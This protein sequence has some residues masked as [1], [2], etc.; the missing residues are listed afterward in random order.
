MATSG[1]T[2]RYLKEDRG[3]Y[4]YRR[5][6]PDRHQKTLGLKMW[7]RPCGD[8]TWAKAVALVTAW[9]EEDDRRIADLDDPAKSSV[10]RE[11]TEARAMAPKLTGLVQAMEAGALPERFDPLDAARAGMKAADQ[12]PEFDTQDKLVR[13]RAILAASFGPHIKVPTD[14]DERDEFDLVKR[15]LERRISELA[16]DPNTISSVAERF[17]VFA[18]IQ[19]GVRGRYR[20]SIRR[21]IQ[22]TGDIPITHLTPA[23][24]RTFRDHLAPTI[25]ASSVQS[26]FTPIKGLLRY[27]VEEELI[28]L[29]PMGSVRLQVE[30]RSIQERRWKP[31][32]PEQMQR[33]F[34][35]MDKF[36][37]KPV[38]N[39]A[40]ERRKAIWMT[41]RVLAFTAMRPKELQW[42]QSEDV[43]D[44]WI[45]VRKSKNAA[46]DRVIPLHPEIADFPAFFHAGGFDTF[47]V[48]KKDR[49]QSV[50]HNFERLTRELM[51]PPLDDPKQVLYSLRSTFSNAM[52]RAGADAEMRRAILGHAEAG[53]LKHY[54]DGPEFAKKRKWVRA[55]DPRTVYPDSGEGD[56]LE[57][58]DD[59]ED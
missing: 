28:D 48:Q 46:S 55:T 38:R 12:N 37:A 31:Y 52:R 50:R 32:A 34:Q 47:K 10:V 58:D 16:G 51:D 19:E 27:A 22:Q 39:L 49:V 36:W 4:F 5:R 23:Q 45:R 26:M 14:P 15:K 44:R 54:D 13:Y 2:V 42:L 33:L 56:D 9:T 20:R 7:N 21:L 6:V 53:A 35:A 18:G 3:R 8:V 1:Q 41:V 29:N 11:D 24:L 25:T 43:T 17:Y 40:E 59:D 57:T 30:K